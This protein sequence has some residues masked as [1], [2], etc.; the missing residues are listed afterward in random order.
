MN[1]FVFFNFLKLCSPR[2]LFEY[3]TLY[4]CASVLISVLLLMSSDSGFPI[5]VIR[6]MMTFSTSSNA[7]IR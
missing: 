4:I 1:N 6:R 5:D 2:L 3:H 7:E